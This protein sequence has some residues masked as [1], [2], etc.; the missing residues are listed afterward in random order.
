VRHKLFGALA[1]SLALVGGAA[2]CTAPP[3]TPVVFVHG[4]LIGP[5]SMGPAVAQF[6]AA[7]YPA[8]N[9][10]V[11]DYFV[12]QD[13]SVTVIAP[14]LAAFVSDVLARTGASRVD[15]LSHS[16]GSL[17]TKQC[18]IVSGCQDKVSHWMSLAGVDN[19]TEV[20]LVKPPLHSDSNEDVQGRTPVIA[21]L[22]SH[23]CRLVDQGVK[24]EVQWTPTDGIV[25][26]PERS[27]EPAP[28][29]NLQVASLNHIT[30]V[31]DPP[32]IAETVRFFGS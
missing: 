26:P 6:E 5:G 16:L 17:V 1:L 8:A 29:V 19:G 13:R 32:V 15:V 14:K 25:V 9:V 7:G 23:W 12:D 10:F 24:V 28:A 3:R 20:E 4:Y 27:R 22:Q 30:I 2:G 11:F 31:G 21:N 18:I